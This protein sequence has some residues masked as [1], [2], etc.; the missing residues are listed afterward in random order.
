MKLK[1]PVPNSFFAEEMRCNYVV[2]E[3][4]KKVWAVELDLLQELL[5]VCNK[6]DLRIWADG[7]T[8]LGAI[9]HHG[10]IPWDDDI[11]MIMLREDYDK[12]LTLGQEFRHP[13]FLQSVYSDPHYTHRHAQLRHSET[14]CWPN[15]SKGCKKRF[16]QGIFIDIFPADNMPMDPR[17]FAK[18]YKKEGVAR[19]KFRMVSK[20]T[21]ALPEIV[22]KL[23]RNHTQCLSDKF[24]YEKYE[25]ILRSVPFQ[26]LGNVCEIS[27][28]HNYKLYPSRHFSKVT[29]VDFEHIQIPVPEFVDE[30]LQL[31]F[32]PDYLIPKQVS[33]EH[34]GMQYDTDHPYFEHLI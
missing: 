26:M 21:N 33:T 6:Y 3:Q 4:M 20:L 24:Y 5:R 14:A 2:T 10:Y 23:L 31:Q 17:S 11:D 25:D 22:Y 32:G 28:K 1:Y 34:G 12:L 27:F 9:R 16:N 30:L 13:F 8:L 7:G 29:M 19:Q 15:S 18:Y